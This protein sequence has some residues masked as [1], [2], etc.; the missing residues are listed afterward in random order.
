MI[1]LSTAMELHFVVTLS[2]EMLI[3]DITISTFE[4]NFDLDYSMLRFLSILLI[5]NVN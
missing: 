2:S 3:S 5:I 1:M 4:S